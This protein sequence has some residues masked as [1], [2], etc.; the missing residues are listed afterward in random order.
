MVILNM[1][2]GLLQSAAGN[3]QT[4]VNPQSFTPKSDEA[5]IENNKQET[6]LD[7]ALSF[8]DNF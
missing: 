6:S 3:G 5:S 2:I 7:D 8:A 4:A 1:L